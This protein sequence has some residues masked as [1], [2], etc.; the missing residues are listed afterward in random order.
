MLAITKK[1]TISNKTVGK[2]K[3]LFWHVFE[4]ICIIANG[5]DDIFVA[6]L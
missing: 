5:I 2:C 3:T 1:P 4:T 6:I